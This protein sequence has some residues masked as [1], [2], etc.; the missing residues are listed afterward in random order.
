[1][2]H[3][4][5]ISEGLWRKVPVR[6]FAGDGYE[7][8]DNVAQM[9]PERVRRV[10]ALFQNLDGDGTIRV[11]SGHIRHNHHP[12]GGVRPF[13][14][15]ST[16]RTQLP[17]GPDVVP[18]WSRNTPYSGVSETLVFHRVSIP[19]RIRI[20]TTR[21]ICEDNS[22]SWHLCEYQVDTYVHCFKKEVPTKYIQQCISA[23]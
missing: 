6:R 12:Q 16:C 19:S 3:G 15:K 8:A 4:L 23:A 13:H 22:D 14:Q 20:T 9:R 17:L 18:T 7:R 1:M 10:V 21:L 2:I 11:D 5:G